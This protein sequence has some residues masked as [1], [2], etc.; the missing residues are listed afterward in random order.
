MATVYLA[1]DGKHH[2]EVALKV[3]R[4][5]LAAAVGSERFLRE[6]RITAGLNHPHILPLLDSGTSEGVFFYVMPFVAGGSLRNLLRAGTPIPLEMVLRI[7][8]EVA[9]ALDYAHSQGVFH[10]DIK[11]E[12]IL[13]N[14][15]LAVVSDFGIARAVSDAQRDGVTRKSY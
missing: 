9:S 15:G 12:N 11:P 7:S 5:D 4:Q 2:R 10:R 6:I 13:F 3:L 14:E 1:M 8:Q